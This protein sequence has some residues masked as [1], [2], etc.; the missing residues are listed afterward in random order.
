MASKIDKALN[1]TTI[2]D[3]C[4]ELIFDFLEWKDL[5]NIAE[6]SKMLYPMAC[7]VFKR[8]YGKAKINCETQIRYKTSNKWYP[9]FKL[10][11]FKTC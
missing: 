10:Y 4:K 9:I 2:N 11:S 7:V 8:K 1:L 5:L 3:D 6:T